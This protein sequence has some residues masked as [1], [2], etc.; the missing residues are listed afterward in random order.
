MHHFLELT[1]V[2]LH[3]PY[4]FFSHLL[5]VISKSVMFRSQIYLQQFVTSDDSDVTQKHFVWEVGLPFNILR[6]LEMTP[7]PYKFT[8]LIRVQGYK[9][10]KVL[11]TNS[12]SF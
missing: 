8:P 7:L 9:C 12:I 11:R 10:H 6:F 1:L 5:W 2:S 3:F 4:Y